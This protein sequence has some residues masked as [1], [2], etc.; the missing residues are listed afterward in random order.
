MAGIV[1]QAIGSEGGGE[2]GTHQP[3]AMCVVRRLAAACTHE[4]SRRSGNSRSSIPPSMPCSEELS[5]AAARALRMLGPLPLPCGETP[6][7][8]T[9]GADSEGGG[10]GCGGGVGTREEADCPLLS[11]LPESTK[12]AKRAAKRVAAGTRSSIPPRVSPRRLRR[13]CTISPMAAAARARRAKPHH[14]IGTSSRPCHSA[15]TRHRSGG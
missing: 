9:A 11:T 7:S 12:A 10:E 1:A 2:G 3:S 8:A 13:W 6:P 4:G 15:S 5:A 14:I